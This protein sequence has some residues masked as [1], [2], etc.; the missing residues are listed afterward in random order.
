MREREKFLGIFFIFFF[1]SVVFFGLSKM[2]AMDKI[3]FFFE[4]VISPIQRNVFNVTRGLTTF[5]KGSSPSLLEENRVLRKQL[6]DQKT[7]IED[8]KALRDQFQTSIPRSQNLLPARIIGAPSLV[9]GISEPEIYVLDKGEKDG[10]IVGQVVVFKN[11]LVG[12][13]SKAT[14][15]YSLVTLIINPDFSATARDMET[16]ALGVVK[17]QGGDLMVFDNVLL[18]DQLGL[19]DLVVTKGEMDMRGVGI[20][21]DIIVGKITSVDKK[22]S[23]LFQTASLKSLLDFSRI[24][25]VF[26]YLQ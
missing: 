24:E 10:V 20:P 5:V 11:Y 23:A 3:Q 17:G 1:L 14:P 4:N 16:E 6:V 18:S 25:M 26:I 2:G 9:P 15:H 22:P 8:N 7:L 19:S 13:I 12:K 21:K